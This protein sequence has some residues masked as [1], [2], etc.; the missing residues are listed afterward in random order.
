MKREPE[1]IDPGLTNTG[2][3][4][5]VLIAR[6]LKGEM[7]AFDEIMTRYRDKIFSFVSHTLRDPH[8]A[9][10]VAQEVFIRAYK[11][12]RHFRGDA[13]LFTWLYRIAMN[14]MYTRTRRAAR[15]RWVHAQAFREKGDAFAPVPRTPE[16]L[17]E[18]REQSTMILMAI[19]QLDP[20]FR[21]VVVLRELEGLDVREV[22]EILNLP[23]GTVKSRLHRALADL[24]RII[25]EIKNQAPG[26]KI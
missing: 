13:K 21:E 17:A 11:S 8:E 15:H 5:D 6:T 10:D 14:V 2:Q 18:S 16:E 3:E 9:E 20:R 4:D 12:L 26:E 24:R 22:A 1:A 25:L 23:E 7:A 19:K